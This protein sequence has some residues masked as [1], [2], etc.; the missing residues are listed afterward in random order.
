ML[1]LEQINSE[2]NLTNTLLLGVFSSKTFSYYRNLGVFN[3]ST[4]YG[5]VGANPLPWFEK[6]EKDHPNYMT[7]WF[8][9]EIANMM[10]WA[11]TILFVLDDVHFPI[12]LERSIT[13][14]ELYM[15]CSQPHLF[16]KTTFVKGDIVIDFDKNLVLS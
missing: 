12:S 7:T 5:K 6:I 15:I 11:K 10:E 8:I 4:L 2:M 9:K 13:C 14:R 16:E 3:Y 1:P